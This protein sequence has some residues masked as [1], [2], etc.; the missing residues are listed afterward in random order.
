MSASLDQRLLHAARQQIM[1]RREIDARTGCWNWTGRV[2]DRGYGA[3]S[4]FRKQTKAHRVSWI[5]HFGPIPAGIH[6]LHRC[7]NR[8]CMNPRHLFLGS[9]AAN[10]ADKARKKRAWIPPSIRDFEPRLTASQVEYIRSTDIAGTELARQFG[11][12]ATAIYHIR[13]GRSYRSLLSATPTS[14]P[15][16]TPGGA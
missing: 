1:R 4:A 5:V 8:K 7:D 13:A 11:L 14:A 16:P 15:Y 6:V 10:M 3:I 12:T 9:N 2:N